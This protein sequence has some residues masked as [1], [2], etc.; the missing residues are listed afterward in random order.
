MYIQYSKFRCKHNCVY[1]D[2]GAG[3]KLVG[4]RKVG[5]MKFF[6]DGNPSPVLQEEVRAQ[7]FLS[8]KMGGNHLNHLTVRHEP[9]AY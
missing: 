8:Q 7:S 4:K 6:L 3:V 5:T 2:I 9:V 1:C